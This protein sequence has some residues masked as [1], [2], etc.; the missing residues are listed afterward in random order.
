MRYLSEPTLR[1]FGMGRARG[2]EEWKFR[3]AAVGKADVP[4]EDWQ[5]ALVGILQKTDL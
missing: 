2:T 5:R 3:G 4:G 1:M